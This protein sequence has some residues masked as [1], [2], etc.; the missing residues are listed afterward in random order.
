MEINSAF[1]GLKKPSKFSDFYA[2][3]SD[4]ITRISFYPHNEFSQKKT[5]LFLTDCSRDA[6]PM[7]AVSQEVNF[8]DSVTEMKCTLLRRISVSVQFSNGNTV[9]DHVYLFL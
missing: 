2:L 1:K 8:T 5:R 4:E 6:V 3:P 7:C 9:L